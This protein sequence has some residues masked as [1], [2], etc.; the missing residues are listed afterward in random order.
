MS[1][2]LFQACIP[3]ALLIA[4]GYALGRLNTI[5]I[6]SVATLVIYAITPLV[7]FGSA[8]QLNFTPSLLLLPVIT[9]LIA[10]AIGLSFYA[11]GSGMPKGERALLPVA[12]GSGNT[13]YFGLPIAI[14]LFGNE[15]AGIYFLANLGVVIFETSLGFYF[16]A[17]GNL[18]PKEALHRVLRLPVLYA[19]TLGICFAAAHIT[20]PE[21][22]IKLWELCKGAYVVLGMM[23]AGLA[24]AQS[25]KFSLH[26]RL[27]SLVFAGKFIAW[28]TAVVL[29][30]LLGVGKF[31]ELEYKLL[32]IMAL[33]P[34]AGNLPAFAA[35]NNEPVGDAAM[36]VLVSTILAI[37]AMPFALPMLLEL[38]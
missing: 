22:G 28:P 29:F 36:L 13:G 18:T 35:A 15:A 11:F 2:L 24:L 5:D 19:L 4:L 25:N 37:V 38:L 12:C 27:S 23:I 1:Q 10:S 33:A 34:V 26:V 6:K 7:A 8:A 32:L 14:S 9:F 20:L 31:T 30:A 16:I 17:R 21:A 3:M